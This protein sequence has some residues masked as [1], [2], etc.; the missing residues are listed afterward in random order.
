MGHNYDLD[1]GLRSKKELEYWMNRCPIKILEQ[2]LLE[3]N[4][5]TELE[6]DK[7]HSDIGREVEEALVFA[8]ESP[9]PDPDEDDTLSVFKGHM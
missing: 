3:R 5:I 8:K 7:I 4:I 1:K 6:R 9:F 2:Q